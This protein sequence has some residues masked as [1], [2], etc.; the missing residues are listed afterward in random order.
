MKKG[1]VLLVLLFI[2]AV[3][4]V[5]AFFTFRTPRDQTLNAYVAALQAKGE[6]MTF[7]ELMASLSPHTNNSLAILTNVVQQLGPPP[8]DATNVDL[9]R[10]TGPARA[11]VAWKLPEP[12]WAFSAPGSPH[13]AWAEVGNRVTSMAAPLAS[14]REALRVPAPNGGVRT[15]YFETP[16]PMLAV[17]TASFWLAADALWNLHTDRR[18]EALASLQAIAGLANLHREEYYLVSQMT[19]VAVAGIGLNLTWEALQAKDWSDSQLLALQNCWAGSDFLETAEKGFEGERCMGRESINLYNL[20]R[21][22]HLYNLY[23]RGQNVSPQNRL[24]HSFYGKYFLDGD[25][26]LQLRHLQAYLDQVRTLR[27]NRSWSEVS[28][29]L[30][31]LNARIDGLTNSLMRFRYLITLVATPNFKRAV[32]KSVQVETQ[33][34]LAVTAIALERY[35]RQ[36]GQYPPSLD[37]LVPQ[38]LPFVPRDCMSG[39]PLRYQPRDRETFLLYSVGEDGR[40]NG[41]DATPA[42]PNAKPGLWEGRDAAWP[43]A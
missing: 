33:R 29:S 37:A 14:L 23:R 41:G 30:D 18:A 16:T 40:D 7:Q 17:K 1:S 5:V 3:L 43:S 15:S 26:L 2:L 34:R 31:Q 42:Q 27:A 28:A 39:Q 22:G 12:S 10:F 38:C 35:R 32:L 4:A 9:M 25:L 21:R 6:K 11:Q 8:A 20:Y 13:P 24:G 19:R 36:H